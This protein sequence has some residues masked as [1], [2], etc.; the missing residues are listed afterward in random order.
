MGLVLGCP[1]VDEE[2]GRDEKRAGDHEGDAEFGAPCPVVPFLKPAVYA[3]VDRRAYLRSQE[4]PDAEGD[5]VQAADADAFVVAGFPQYG[6][7]GEDK[8]HEA[9]EVSHVDGE[10]LD[11]DLSAEEDEGS[12]DGAFHCIGEGAFRVFVFRVEGGVVGFFAEFF[13]FGVE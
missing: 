10:D 5:I 12:G 9:V 8:V 4:E 13:G 2:A 11:D 1:A 7:G 3:I 6:E